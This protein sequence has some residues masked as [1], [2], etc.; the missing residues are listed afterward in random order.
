MVKVFL[1][2][3]FN[4]QNNSEEICRIFSEQFSVSVCVVETAF[5]FNVAKKDF[6]AA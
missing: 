5:D 6:D 3:F 1:S 4:C 2:D